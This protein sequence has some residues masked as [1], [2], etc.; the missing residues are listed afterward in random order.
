MSVT[1]C[2]RRFYPA[3]AGLL[4]GGTSVRCRSARCASSFTARTDRSCSSR[5]IAAHER[6]REDARGDCLAQCLGKRRVELLEEVGETTAE[7]T[8][9]AVQERGDGLGDDHHRH[10][11]REQHHGQTD[12][13]VNRFQHDDSL[14]RAETRRSEACD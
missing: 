1:A 4:P 5:P 11:E 8:A 14:T 10:A 2:A 6:V 12:E 9:A 7:T 3:S 13:N